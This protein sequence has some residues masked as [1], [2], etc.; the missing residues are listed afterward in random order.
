MSQHIVFNAKGAE[1]NCCNKEELGEHRVR[2][3][4]QSTYSRS[5]SKGKDPV[6]CCIFPPL[7][8]DGE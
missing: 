4:S 1:K 3:P 2:K 8:E 6:A 5:G 7:P